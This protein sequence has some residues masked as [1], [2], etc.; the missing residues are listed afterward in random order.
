MKYVFFLFFVVAS[1]QVS[2]QALAEHPFV[3]YAQR[4]TVRELLD[5]VVEAGQEREFVSASNRRANHAF[6]SFE[7]LETSLLDSP[8]VSVVRCEDVLGSDEFRTETY[9]ATGD[10]AGSWFR[11]CYEG[12][13][14]VLYDSEPIFSLTCGN[15]IFPP[16]PS[17]PP[18]PKTATAF[19][20][21]CTDVLVL[22]PAGHIG[23]PASRKV[24]SCHFE[25]E[26]VLLD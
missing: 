5:A 10:H 6:G 8:R 20:C 21:E 9:T 16:P 4:E 23:G 11:G 7:E 22:G 24:M 12:E 19:R 17:P 18:P 14:L 25:R 3:P 13:Y 2:A 26:V 1:A 15:I